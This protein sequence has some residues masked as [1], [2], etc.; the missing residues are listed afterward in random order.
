M[1]ETGER[2]SLRVYILCEIR[3]QVLRSEG[4]GVGEELG[5]ELQSSGS[6]FDFVLIKEVNDGMQC[7]VSEGLG[8]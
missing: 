2:A 8:Q 6:A 4:P 5:E 3:G 7:A 1:S